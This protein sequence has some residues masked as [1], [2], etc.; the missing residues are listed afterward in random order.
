M[1]LDVQDAMARACFVSCR[2]IGRF[3]RSARYSRVGFVFA[4]GELRVRKRRAC[5]APPLIWLGDFLMRLLNTGVQVLPQ[6]EWEERER[7]AYASVYGRSVAVAGDGALLLPMLAGKTLATLLQ[8]PQ[9]EEALRTKAIKAAVVALAALHR[10][11][12]THADA[13]ADNVLVDLE[14]GVARWFD[15]ET[16]HQATRPMVWRAGPG[17]RVRPS[18]SSSA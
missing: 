15:F 3:V 13:M 5:H 10:L 2:A 1:R 9:T 16:V 11:G 14:A 8:D 12:L 17:A 7:C 6:H 4:D 18:R